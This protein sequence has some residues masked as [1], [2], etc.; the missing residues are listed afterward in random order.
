MKKFLLILIS[1]TL[2]FV[3]GC[4]NNK[5]DEISSYIDSAGFPH[6]VIETNLIYKDNLP[7]IKYVGNHVYLNGDYKV[8]NGDEKCSLN[9]IKEG[10]RIKV[11]AK[12]FVVEELPHYHFE[13]VYK[14]DL[15]K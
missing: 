10:T 6:V 3:S 9:E 15:V 8:T 5:K 2:L 13:H 4:K 12:D 7:C 14:I 1:F 11:D